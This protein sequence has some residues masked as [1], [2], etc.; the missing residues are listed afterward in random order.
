MYQTTESP[1][2]GIDRGPALWILLLRLPNCYLHYSYLNR[3]YLGPL[4]C[5]HGVFD[6]GCILVNHRLYPLTTHK[7]VH[8]SSFPTPLPS[9][10]H[11]PN[12]PPLSLLPP[13]PSPALYHPVSSRFL[14]CV[15]NPLYFCYAGRR[16]PQTCVINPVLYLLHIRPP[17]F[18][19]FLLVFALPSESFDPLGTFL[20]F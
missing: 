11:I 6:L 7:G 13:V 12:Y 3:L 8:P 20:V 19:F 9:P 4:R 14:S 16:P 5:V 10:I 17:C 18:V 2:L 1:L 15:S